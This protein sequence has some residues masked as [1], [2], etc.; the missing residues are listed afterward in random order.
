MHGILHIPVQPEVGPLKF[1]V[2]QFP[3]HV[4]KPLYMGP[5][6]FIPAGT[7]FVYNQHLAGLFKNGPEFKK[8]LNES[9]I[10]SMFNQVFHAGPCQL[11]P[12]LVK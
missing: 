6:K 10:I 9:N 1:A 4:Y 12:L 8:I 3:A 11:P 2:S 7:G 5:I